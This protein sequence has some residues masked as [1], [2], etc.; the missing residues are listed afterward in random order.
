MFALCTFFM[1]S[2]SSPGVNL[3]FEK[4]CCMTGVWITFSMYRTWTKMRWKGHRASC[5]VRHS[6]LRTWLSVVYIPHWAFGFVSALLFFLK[7]LSRKARGMH[8]ACAKSSHSVCTSS[9][10][11]ELQALTPQHAAKPQR[12][13]FLVLLSFQGRPRALKGQVVLPLPIPCVGRK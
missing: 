13:S 8:S 9:P 11:V 7:P 12:Q 10:A 3:H 6:A 5:K 1:I 2:S 4:A